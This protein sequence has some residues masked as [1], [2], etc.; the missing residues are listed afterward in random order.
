M[1]YKSIIAWIIAFILMIGLA[2]YQRLTGPTHPKRGSIE[3]SGTTIKY[4]LPRSFGG[5]GDADVVLEIPDKSISG[6]IKFKRY[7][8]HDDWSTNKMQRDGN[9]LI[10]YLPHLPPAGKVMYEIFLEKNGE[11][12][13]LS[14]EPVIL[15]FKGSVPDFFLYPHIFFMFLAMVFSARA[16]I[17]GLFK[18]DN[19]YKLSLYTLILFAIGGLILGPIVQYYAFGALWT[20]WPFAGGEFNLL[21]FGDL[22]DNKTLAGIL[23][24]VIAVIKMKQNPNS[25]YMALIAALVLIAVYLIP[26]SLLGSEIDFRELENVQ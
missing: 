17:S 22:T 9:K 5:P 7:K 15:R 24:W 1:N 8:S 23:A 18:W 3:I 11:K 13:M 6:E 26:H 16:A 19:T 20:G 2:V 10:A 12:K 4:S 21:K 14:N 25:K